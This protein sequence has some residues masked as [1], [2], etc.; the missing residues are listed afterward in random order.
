MFKKLNLCIFKDCQSRPSFNFEG[1]K[2]RYCSEHKCENMIDVHHRKCKHSGC[3]LTASFG[4]EGGTNDFCSKHKK[5]TMIA[6][7]GVL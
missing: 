1:E 7:V 4:V 2:A 5:E 3:K 6:V